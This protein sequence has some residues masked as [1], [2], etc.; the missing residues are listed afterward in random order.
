MYLGGHPREQ[1]SDEGELG[2]EEPGCVGR[3]GSHYPVMLRDVVIPHQ[4]TVAPVERRCSDR[5]LSHGLLNQSGPSL[6]LEVPEPQT[7]VQL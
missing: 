1:G 4:R 6:D 3:A 5:T 2:M 7:S